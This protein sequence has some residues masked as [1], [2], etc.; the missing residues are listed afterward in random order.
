[1]HSVES[2]L[3][4][5]QDEHYK[6]IMKRVKK[7]DPVATTAM[8]KKHYNEIDYVRAA[9]YWTKAAELGDVKAHVGLG[10]LYRNGNGV[11]K[12]QEKAVYH[13]EQAAIGG[14]PDARHNLAAHEMDNDRIERAAKHFIINAYLGDDVSLKHIKDLFVEG[15]VSKEDYAAALRGYQAAVDATKSAER[16]K[17]AEAKTKSGRYVFD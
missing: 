17:A 2:R 14:H 5:S 13:F 8:G 15:V 10:I 4:K 1:M 16:E 6:N 3:P 9:E 12:D 7:N 11:E